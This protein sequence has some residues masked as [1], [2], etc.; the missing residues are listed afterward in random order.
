M[1]FLIQRWPLY[2]GME[3]IWGF[4]GTQDIG[5]LSCLISRMMRS[6]PRGSRKGSAASI[7]G[8][9]WTRNVSLR[10]PRKREL[11][12]KDTGQMWK[13]WKR[14][15]GNVDFFF[16]KES[17]PCWYDQGKTHG[18]LTGAKGYGC[19]SQSLMRSSIHICKI[20]VLTC[21]ILWWSS[22]FRFFFQTFL[23]CFP[24]KNPCLFQGRFRRFQPSENRG[25][26]TRQEA[27]QSGS[28][29]NRKPGPSYDPYRVKM[30]IYTLE[31]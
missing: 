6:I 16:G 15:V 14:V 27:A 23:F 12:Q 21:D 2:E 30:G 5:S 31:D 18:N 19:T 28:L 8:P 9:V 7:L 22:T 29:M 4:I 13:G 11:Q 10:P 24:T 1:I 17:D 20:I 26:N 25:F 3:V